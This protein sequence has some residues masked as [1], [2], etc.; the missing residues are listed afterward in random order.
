[1]GAASRQHTL[2]GERG[3]L[4]DMAAVVMHGDW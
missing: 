4:E 2:V 1:M 3:M